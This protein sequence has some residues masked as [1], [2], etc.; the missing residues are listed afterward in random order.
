M[1]DLTNDDLARFSQ[2][3]A[4]LDDAGRKQLMARATKH[5]AAAN[6]VL[7][8][9]GEAGTDFFV[10][11]RGRV[12]VSGDDLGDAR[13][14]ATLTAGQ[15]FGE[16]AVLSGQK[17]QATVTALGPVELLCFPG[18]A[19]NEVLA[20]APEARAVLQKVGLLR[21]EDAMQKLMS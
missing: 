16:V 18:A 1:S 11:V 7:C 21:T 20:G 3:F 14:L 12:Q 13:T 15:F 17:R 2:L 19:V 8:R 4:A 6:E 5:S 9:E 10:I